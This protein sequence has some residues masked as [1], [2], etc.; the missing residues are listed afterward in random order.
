MKPIDLR[1]MT[2]VAGLATLSALTACN[3]EVNI[4]L[5]GSEEAAPSVAPLEPAPLRPPAPLPP[6]PAPEGWTPRGGLGTPPRVDDVVGDALWRPEEWV[7]NPA[8]LD[9]HR[10]VCADG[11]FSE[12]TTAPLLLNRSDI[13]GVMAQAYPGELRDAGVGGT[14]HILLCI[15]QDGRVSTTR[16]DRS[17]GIPQL[18]NAAQDVAMR[19]VFDPA[20][21]AGVD[22]AAWISFPITFR[23]R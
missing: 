12:Y 19:F 9:R 10:D 21:T 15:E 18:D 16:V 4:H 5:D 8:N 13:A 2:T 11:G 20:K 6:D 14:T 22:I 7:E 3:L 23:V 1:F 17:S